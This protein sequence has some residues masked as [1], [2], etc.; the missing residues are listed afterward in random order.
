VAA[1]VAI[2]PEAVLFLWNLLD[3]SDTGSWI[4]HNWDVIPRFL[5]SG[6]TVAVVFTTLALFVASFTNR[7]AYAA[8]GTVAVLFIG[9]AV[10]GIA[11]DNFNGTLSDVL[12]EADI[13]RSLVDTV[14]WVFGDAI[15]AS[16]APGWVSAL[17][18]LGLAGRA[19]G[20][21]A[22]PDRADGAR[23]SAA[24][25]PAIA[26]DRL[27]RWFGGV[28]AVSD[29][30]LEVGPGVT[31]LLGPNGAGQ[32]DAAAHDRRPDRAVRGQRARLRRDG[33]REPGDLPPH[34]LHARARGC[35]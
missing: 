26:I 19:R 34:R 17:W 27:S 32:D 24:E 23:L 6:L 28:V 25:Q 20:V 30:T 11:H 14:H 9:G 16:Q 4:R 3:A 15:D 35:L 7:R 5:A 18:V 21:A 22:A 13:L 2:I 10:G 1:T 8:I 12:S 29:V 31:A 33:A